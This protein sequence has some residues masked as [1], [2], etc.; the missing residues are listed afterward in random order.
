M[1]NVFCLKYKQELEGLDR[2]P[3]PGELGKKIY[4]NISKRAWKDWM[5]YQTKLVNE[6][7]LKMF[8]PA[9]QETIKKHAEEFFFASK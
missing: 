5:E 8:E 3:Y 9:A 2:A 6:L 4:E 7:K 1:R